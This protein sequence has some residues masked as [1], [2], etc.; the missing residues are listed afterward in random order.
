MLDGVIAVY[1]ISSSE[2][3]PQYDTMYV[4]FA[5]L[6]NFFDDKIIQR[7]DNV[8]DIGLQVSSETLQNT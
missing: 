1:N 5:S 7:H 3:R 4:T 2:S 8:K 6:C